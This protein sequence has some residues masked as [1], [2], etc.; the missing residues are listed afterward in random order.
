MSEAFAT[1]ILTEI[2]K[3]MVGIFGDRLTKP[4]RPSDLTLPHLIDLHD[5]LRGV[6]AHVAQLIKFFRDLAEGRQTKT[7]AHRELY[8]I[9]HS[10][11]RSLSAAGQALQHLNPVLSI[12]TD[13]D[14]HEFVG[15]FLD[16]DERCAI[17]YLAG[18][19]EEVLG[20]LADGNRPP[21]RGDYWPW[22]QGVQPSASAGDLIERLE[23]LKNQG[24]DARRGVA[25][26]IRKVYG[27][28]D[29]RAY[30]EERDGGT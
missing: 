18:L 20:Y 25:E 13:D 14:L 9:L 19:D 8:P 7:V 22:P 24:A 2:F 4:T 30:L 27:W 5:Q 16:G 21:A 3:K 23:A 10:T 15:D 17:D 28:N 26:F 6:E 29:V 11:R 12:M 1:T